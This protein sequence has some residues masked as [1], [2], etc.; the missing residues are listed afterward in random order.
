ML[1]RRWIGT[2]AMGLA[3][4]AT[5]VAALDAQGTTAKQATGK[6]TVTLTGCL[7]GPIPD[8]EYALSLTPNGPVGTTGA[9]ATLTYR[10]TNV[11]T[12]ASPASAVYVVMGTEKQL[13][14]HPG[15]Q[16]QIT[17][18]IVDAGPRGTAG[19]TTGLAT[20]DQYTGS[21]VA[22]PRPARSTATEPMLR[23]E[24]VKMVSATCAATR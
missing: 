20:A 6:P 11:T 14:A 1:T 19:E 22:A 12:K 23:V 7:Q 15:H 16:V 24:S 13:S 9:G 4:G 2:C 10:L 5:A 21:A 18:T 17:G 8:D 3:I